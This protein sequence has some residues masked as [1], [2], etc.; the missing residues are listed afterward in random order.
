[1]AA[2]DETDFFESNFGHTNG[3]WRAKGRL[4]DFAHSARLAVNPSYRG[5]RAKAT[6]HPQRRILI[7]AVEVPKR[8]QD[9]QD[10]V[11]RLSCSHHDI[12]LKIAPLLAGRG[13]F[14]NIN[15][16][17]EGVNLEVYDW[18]IIVDDDIAFEN[19]FLDKFICVAE[20]AQLD[21]CM[22]AHKFRSNQAF[23]LTTRKWNT[24]ARVTHF[25]ES[26]PLT[27]FRRVTYPHILPF[28]EIRWAWG[29]DIAWSE[30]ARER[31]FRMGI[32]DATPLKHLRPV[33]GSYDANIAMDGAKAF[34]A[35]KG[36][37]RKRHEILAS[38]ET[39]SRFNANQNATIGQILISATEFK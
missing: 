9:L 35:S 38:V 17:L 12:T 4:L 8:A 15:A 28:P 32:V 33:A 1:M 11:K 39:I 29:T 13:K 23:D 24:L 20:L 36:I 5:L 6:S 3:V 27:A 25:V 34:L 7:T 19:G 21:I 10:V 16:A 30:M 2:S 18:I 37:N 31:G 26:G 22:P 14:Q